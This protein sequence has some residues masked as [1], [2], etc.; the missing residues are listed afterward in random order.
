M[1][2]WLLGRQPENI[3]TFTNPLD[4]LDTRPWLPTIGCLPAQY[5]KARKYK[6]LTF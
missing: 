2:E 5:F 4:T 3:S 1:G 6:I